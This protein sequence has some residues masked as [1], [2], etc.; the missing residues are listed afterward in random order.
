MRSTSEPF[1]DLYPTGSRTL[2]DATV[3]AVLA[4]ISGL[5]QDTLF[6]QYIQG[7]ECFGDAFMN[8][9]DKLDV[10]PNLYIY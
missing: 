1:T 10:Q 7:N 9:S 8:T 3:A 5:Y 6:I 2:I 4:I